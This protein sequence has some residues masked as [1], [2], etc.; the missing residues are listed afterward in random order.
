MALSS[1]RLRRLTLK[2]R[3]HKTADAFGRRC[4]SRNLIAQIEIPSG[5]PLWS[6]Q[7]V[8]KLANSYDSIRHFKD[9]WRLK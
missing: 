5:A 7:F 3:R 2:F 9:V 4:L 6:Y 1:H 8:E